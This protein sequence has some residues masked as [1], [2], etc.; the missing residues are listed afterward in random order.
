[1]TCLS[2]TINTKIIVLLCHTLIPDSYYRI[3]AALIA[4]NSLVDIILEE[5]MISSNPL[6]I[7]FLLHTCNHFL[8]HT[9]H[10]FLDYTLKHIC[11]GLLHTILNIRLDSFFLI[12]WFL[13]H[14]WFLSYNF[15]IFLF[16]LPYF[17]RHWS[18]LRLIIINIH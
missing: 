5:L 2:F 4:L 11:I 15:V 17:I 14:N 13:D 12:N 3:H 1:M 7:I 9:H 8:H 10:L 16:R 18:D 6:I